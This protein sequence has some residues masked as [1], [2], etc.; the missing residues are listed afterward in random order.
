M[1]LEAA[2]RTPWADGPG[3]SLL[4]CLFPGLAATF[5]ASYPGTPF[6]GE[7][8][9]ARLPGF[10]RELSLDR[11]SDGVGAEPGLRRPRSRAIHQFE[12]FPAKRSHVPSEPG[13]GSAFFRRRAAR[14]ARKAPPGDRVRSTDLV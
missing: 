5:L 6:L 11:L 1:A 9:L 2:Q 12:I 3:G 14:S 13:A 10:V 8:P 4:D 7:G